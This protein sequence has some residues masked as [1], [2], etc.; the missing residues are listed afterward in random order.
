MLFSRGLPG[1]FGNLRGVVLHNALC[2]PAVQGFG[3]QALCNLLIHHNERRVHYGKTN[4]MG[5]VF[6]NDEGKGQ[7]GEKAYL[8]GLL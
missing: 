4:S 7:E 8:D 5:N 3:R 2:L 6:N 1:I